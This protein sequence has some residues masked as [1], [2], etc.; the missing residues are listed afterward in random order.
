MKKIYYIMLLLTTLAVTVSCS[1]DDEG[2]KLSELTVQLTSDNTVND[3]TKF[4]IKVTD[5][6]SGKT[7]SL[8]ADASGK[9]AFNLPLGSYNIVA[10]DNADGASTMYGHT[11]NYMLSENAATVEIKLGSIINT[12]EKTFVLDELY[13]NG[14]KNGEYEYIYYESYLTIT[15]VSDRP[16][17]ADGLSI[18]ICGDY[19]SIEASD[20][21]PMPQ[22]LKKDSVVITQLYTI[23]GDGRTYKVEPGKS[24]VLAHTAINNKLDGNGNA[25]PSKTNSIDLSGADFEF[26]VPYE[27]SMTTDNPEVPNMIVDYSMNQAFNWGY[28]GS[29]PI[30]LVRLDAGKKAEILANKVNLAIPASYG[31]MKMDH[32]LLP[33]SSI[34]DGVETGAADNLFRK[35]LP[36]R[37][38]RGSVL[39]SSGGF[40]GGFDGQF[41]KR[42]ITIGTDGKSTVA[43]TN[44]ST[45][46]FEII[47]HG[48][49]SYPKK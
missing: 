38:D 47:P 23:P 31:M 32:L 18:A 28:S 21:D 17:Y 41:I 35:V 20:S 12:M 1:D 25:D 8:N 4:Q 39:I 27:Y 14:D 19:N 36:D 7:T 33:V 26:Y 22:Y 24:L 13:F 5:L 42:K 34:I 46:D 40:S 30:M 29:T 45:D 48:Q 15:N 49:K 37:V 6:K 10:E 2:A 43:D 44:N 9:A 16:L 11:E 3:Y